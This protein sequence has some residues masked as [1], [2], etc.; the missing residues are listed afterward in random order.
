M[1]KYFAL[2]LILII[3]N[4]YAQDHG[5]MP[6]GLRLELGLGYNQLKFRSLPTEFRSTSETLLRNEFKVTP[7]VR[8][9]WEKN[10]F[11]IFSIRPF[12][13]YSII[14]G[15]SSKSENGYEDEY[16]FE[17][18]DAGL[19]INYKIQN[20][21][22]AVGGKYNRFLNVTGRFYGDLNFLSETNRQWNEKDM[23]SLFKK[24]SMNLGGG[25]GYIYKK[26]TIS[27]E[28]WFSISELIRD[29]FENLS[30]VSTKRFQ[31]LFGYQL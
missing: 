12:I 29:D 1:K 15:K 22:F 5:L 10:I 4:I 17:T 30:E 13:S 23:S 11:Y 8:L 25:I 26:F 14:G 24:Y 16:S 28:G 9:S 31:L 3:S 21:T 6:A 18:I 7:T 20:I 19:F 2:L 27:M